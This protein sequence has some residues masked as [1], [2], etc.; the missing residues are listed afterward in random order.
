MSAPGR[1]W[2]RLTL[3]WAAVIALLTLLPA[4]RLPLT[5]TWRLL[6]FDT[7]AHAGVFVVLASLLQRSWGT[8]AGRRSF[9]GTFAI[10]LAY[11]ALIEW[12][13]TAMHLGRHGEWSDLLSD[14]LGALIG[15]ALAGML[16]RRQQ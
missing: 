5:P 12:L 15:A 16:P 8:V 6:S 1:W 4:D 9:L 7:A 10:S 3:A 14:G 13:Q 2:R 11:G